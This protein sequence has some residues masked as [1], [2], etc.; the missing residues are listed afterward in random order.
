MKDNQHNFDELKRLL[1][2]KRHEISPPGY[3]NHFSDQ[4]I[5][6][7]R[8]GEAG[9]S[10][11][12]DAV[13]AEQAPWLLNFIRLFETRPGVVGAFATILCLALVVGVVFTELADRS[14]KKLAAITDAASVQPSATTVAAVAAPMVAGNPALDAGG[15]VASTNPVTSLQPVNTLFGQPNGNSMFQAASFAPAH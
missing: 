15:I 10:H 4:V 1:K 9:G 2:L 12:F 5:S 11:S 7:I 14:A 13:L 3:F 6:R 8:A